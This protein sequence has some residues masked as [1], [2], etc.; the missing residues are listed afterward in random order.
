MS[1]TLKRKIK[2]TNQIWVR[3]WVG[4]GMLGITYPVWVRVGMLGITYPVWV[5]VGML[6]ITYPVCRCVCSAL[7]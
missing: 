4:V 2:L 1:L 3:V 5:G 6:G 7:T